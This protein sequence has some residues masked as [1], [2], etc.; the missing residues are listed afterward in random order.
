MNRAK[1]WKYIVIYNRIT[2]QT[3]DKK[4]YISQDKKQAF[5]SSISIATQETKSF[6]KSNVSELYI[7]LG[8]HFIILS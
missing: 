8:E 4:T 3:N 5:Y 7:I 6:V 2:G 1:N